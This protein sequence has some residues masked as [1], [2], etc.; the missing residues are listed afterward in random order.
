MVQ[1]CITFVTMSV[2]QPLLGPEL[3]TK[4]ECR[5]RTAASGSSILWHVFATWTTTAAAWDPCGGALAC[6]LLLIVSAAA[7][8]AL[9]LAATLP[10]QLWGTFLNQL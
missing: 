2:Q 4:R 7:L 1:R 6:P 8:L 9:A 10:V 5:Q 3:G